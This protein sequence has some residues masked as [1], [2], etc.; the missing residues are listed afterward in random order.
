MKGG[1]LHR[2]CPA[3]LFRDDPSFA[4]YCEELFAAW[5]SGQLPQ[6]RIPGETESASL[7]E[8]NVLV[9]TWEAHERQEG[10]RFLMDLAS[11]ILGD[12]KKKP[13]GAKK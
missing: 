3:R 11:A 7:R 12:G 2:F 9:R 8:F 6:G 10:R 13:T 1:I 5:K 4:L